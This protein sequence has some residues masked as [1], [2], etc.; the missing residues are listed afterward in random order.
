MFTVLLRD[1]ISLVRSFATTAPLN[2]PPCRGGLKSE[3]ELIDSAGRL[4]D[5]IVRVTL[6]ETG[7]VSGNLSAHRSP[8]GVSDAA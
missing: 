7:I 2:Q 6:K 5:N 4:I 1:Q 3:T 8:R